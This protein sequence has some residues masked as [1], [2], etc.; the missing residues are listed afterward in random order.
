MAAVVSASRV[1]AGASSSVAL[2]RG[3][4]QLKAVKMGK[5][6]TRGSM[7][8]VAAGAV[9]NGYASALVEACADAKALDSV[10]GDIETITAYMAAN[11]AMSTFLANPTMEPKKKKDVLAKL[12]KEASFHPFTSNFL[13]LLVDKARI[14]QLDAIAEE[15][16]ALYCASTDTQVATVTSAVKLENEQQFMIAKKI[17]EMTGAKNIKLKPEVDPSLLGGFVVT[18]GKDG[19]GYI[20][21]SVAGQVR[22]LKNDIVVA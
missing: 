14:G 12:G 5:A 18:Y 2:S 1:V 16:E 9:A 7:V 17:Q 13:N 15:F 22:Q 20:D 21:M 10:H 6:Q 3:R 8:V 11:P 4:A 19:S